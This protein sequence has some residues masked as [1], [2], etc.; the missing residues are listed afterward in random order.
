MSFTLIKRMF[1]ALLASIMFA[2]CASTAN[3]MEAGSYLLEDHHD[4]RIYIFY[5]KKTYKSFKQVGETAYRLTRIGAGPK[6]ET[7]VFGLTK[8]DKKKRSGITAI[9]IY[10]GKIKPGKD[11]YAEMM[12]E[13][14]IYVFNNYEDMQA[15]R[16]VGEAAYRYTDIAAGP[17][18]ETIV[19]VL[20]KK[21]KKKK[22]VELM[23]KFKAFN[24]LS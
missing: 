3:Q 9:D 20:N 6:G 10:D 12:L 8:K 23:N 13:G 14:R 2:G 22:P 18:G 21:N 4:G 19:Y 24:G 5:D 11:F 17:K 7:V 1:L 16:N 15:V